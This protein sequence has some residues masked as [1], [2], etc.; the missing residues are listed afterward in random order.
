MRSTATLLTDGTPEAAALACFLRAMA[1]G[2]RQ[3]DALGPSDVE[4]LVLARRH[5]GERERLVVLATEARAGAAPSAGMEARASDTAP[6]TAVL[7]GSDALAVVRRWLIELGPFEARELGAEAVERRVRAG[8]EGASHVL[9]LAR[10]IAPTKAADV[11]RPKKRGRPKGESNPFRGAGF[12][13]TVAL[14]REPARK[15]TERSLAEAAERSYY[16]VHRILLELDR[17]GFLARDERGT[18]LSNAEGLRDDLA[19]AWAARAGAPRAARHFAPPPRRDALASAL[20]ALREAGIEPVLAGPSALPSGRGLVGAPITLY[21]PGD[22]D[23]A[24]ERAG[25]RPMRTSGG[26][27]RIWPVLEEALVARP[28]ERDDR[29]FTHPVVTYLDLAASA[30]DRER[31]LAHELWRSR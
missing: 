29:L 27:V 20:D 8:D 21:A 28:I 16:A 14:L 18:R 15:F 6:P 26:A 17:R 3:V 10:R 1:P 19:T 7:D 24:L 30:D 23:Q 13:T 25:F 22:A 4:A 9:A 5:A 2:V 31:Q 11:P 12:D